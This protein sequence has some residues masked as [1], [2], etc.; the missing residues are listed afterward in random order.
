MAC[1]LYI[2]LDT[3]DINQMILI[4]LPPVK[5]EQQIIH[6]LIVKYQKNPI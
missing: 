5:S 4:S 2:L 6:S 3:Q 1:T